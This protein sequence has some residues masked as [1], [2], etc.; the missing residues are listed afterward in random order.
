MVSKSDRARSIAFLLMAALSWSLGGLL[1]KSVDWNPLAISGMRSAIASLVILIYLRRPR[2]T[3]SAAQIGGALFYA[4]TVILFVAANRMTTAANAIL[5]QYGAPVYVA[6]WGRRLLGERTAR[7]DWLAVAAVLGGMTLFFMDELEAGSMAG[8]IVAV[9]SGLA[10]AMLIL[11]LRKQKDASPLESCLLGNIF[12]A[13]IGFPFML[14]SVPGPGSWAGLI[15]LG[16]VQV[17]LAYILYTIA[18]KGVTAL[19]ASLIPVIEPILNPLWVFLALGEVPGNW[20]LVGGAVIL[21]TMLV[22]YLLPAW[23]R[24]RKEV[25]G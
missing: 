20:A 24:D 3:W 23:R 7:S 19:E 1:I 8:N 11:F 22:R 9:G 12:A 18:I 21:T 13:G 14:Q 5:L 4:A 6:L 16:T 25:F 2:F 15:I 10:F 17:G